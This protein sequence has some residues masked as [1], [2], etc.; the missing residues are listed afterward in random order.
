MGALILLE[1]SAIIFA[2]GHSG[3]DAVTNILFYTK[4]F[5][6]SDEFCF[7]YGYWRLLAFEM[8]KF[9]MYLVYITQVYI[10][11][12]TSAYRY[13][14]R[15]VIAPMYCM[16]I[17]YIVLFVFFLNFHLFEAG[18][19]GLVCTMQSNWAIVFGIHVPFDLFFCI[20]TLVLFIRPLSKIMAA[21]NSTP[22]RDSR[23]SG[24]D[25][26][27]GVIVK[28]LIL[29]ITTIVSANIFV[30]FQMFEIPLI[31]IDD[32]V[33]SFCILLMLHLHRDLY[34]RCCGKMESR[35]LSNCGGKTTSADPASCASSSSCSVVP[36]TT[37][38]PQ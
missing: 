25:K 10:T 36:S 22:R 27:M 9:S 37:S 21:R 11:Y 13:S 32:A 24:G 23:I 1:M 17:I 16:S 12:K 20:T 2:F 8:T 4:T 35:I 5:T 28:K 34:Q 38:T 3:Y 31:P 18:H 33:N 26:F 14:V 6:L 19:D 15:F 29:I 7:E 30:L